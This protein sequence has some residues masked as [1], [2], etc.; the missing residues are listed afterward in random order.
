MF[1]DDVR[2]IN[3][4]KRRT[5][6]RLALLESVM[7]IIARI[8]VK[9]INLDAEDGGE[10]SDASIS[11]KNSSAMNPPSA[12]MQAAFLQGTAQ[13]NRSRENPQIIVK[14]LLSKCSWSFH[15][16]YLCCW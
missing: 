13:H 1:R 14:M 9:L 12:S 4:D 8:F 5:H 7:E 3:A 2:E 11:L 15:L 16:P 10:S 6:M